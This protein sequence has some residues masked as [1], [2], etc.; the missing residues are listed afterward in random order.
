[1]RFSRPPASG[2][3]SCP[4]AWRD[5]RRPLAPR[6]FCP[7][8]GT[9]GG[10][11]LD[12]YRYNSLITKAFLAWPRPVRSLLLGEVRGAGA[13]HEGRLTMQRNVT[14]LDECREVLAHRVTAVR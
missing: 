4:C 9:M 11:F 12:L 14:N 5:D 7:R 6:A 3:G 1:M 10:V 13:P 2:C 8:S